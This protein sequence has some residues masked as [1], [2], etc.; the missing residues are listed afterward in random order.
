MHQFDPQRTPAG[1]QEP[2]PGDGRR[3][4]RRGFLS[5]SAAA[6][7][8][9]ALAAC[10][11]SSSPGNG[12]T[13]TKEFTYWSMWTKDEPVAKVL[14]QAFAA[15]EHDTGVKV[16]VQW[17]GRDNLTKV[18]AALNT[19]HVP[20]L[21]DNSF[22]GIKSAMGKEALDLTRLD[23]SKVPA[24]PGKTVRDVVPTGY[25][26]LYSLGGKK[27]L[28][29]YYVSAQ[30]WWYSGKAN[31]QLATDPP[32]TWSDF[33]SAMAAMK[34]AGKSPLAQDTDI[35]FYDSAFVYA[36]LQRALGPGGLHKTVADHSGNGWGDPKV[37]QALDAIA[38]LTSKRYYRPGFDSSKYPAMEKDWAH[39]K[40]ELL[41][42]GSWVPYFD[43]PDVAKDFDM[44][45]FN[46]PQLVGTDVSVPVDIFGFSIP[47]KAANGPAAMK[48]LPYLMGKQW[49]TK[50]SHDA[51]IL[52]PRTDI[53]VPGELSDL[54]AIIKANK[55]TPTSDGV[56][57]DYPDLDKQF[58][59]LCRDLITGRS[60]TGKFLTKVKAA[61]VQYW[62]LNG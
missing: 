22:A 62:R 53:T 47:G 27:I 5:V 6:V 9:A 60:D 11:G 32:R 33:T 14:Q 20:D 57:A 55:L 34:A 36:A 41:Y 29:P 52:T 58:E 13:G 17:Q 19:G 2:A 8:S 44:R 37:K 24:E 31:P 59:P 42:M 38:E 56:A 51:K 50:M 43:G 40:A 35:L 18:K 49:L 12:G 48:F 15:F 25:D 26:Q 1:R 30:T 28:V 3:L 23:H 16:H 54:Q 10:G 21:V 7:G 61:Q 39:G 4:S 46:F 45:T